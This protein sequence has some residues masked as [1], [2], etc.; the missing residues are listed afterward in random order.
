MVAPAIVSAVRVLVVEDEESIRRVVVGYL[1]QEGFQ[2]SEAAE[3][4]EGS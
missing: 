3:R 4:A 2:V 1:H